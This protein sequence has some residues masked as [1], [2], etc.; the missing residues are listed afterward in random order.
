MMPCGRFSCSFF[1]DPKNCFMVSCHPR[2]VEPASWVLYFL[3]I[4]II[5]Y[6]SIYLFIFSINGNQFSYM[7]R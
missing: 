3:P 2:G 1:P 4:I 6:L 7:G 5:I